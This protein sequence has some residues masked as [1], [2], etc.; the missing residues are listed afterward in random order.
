MK[1]DQLVASYIR[2]RDKKSALKKDLEGKTEKIDLL[3]KDME[4]AI[5]KTFND[6]GQESAR[7]EFGTAYK[8]V[9]TS[10]SVASREDFLGWVLTDPDDR[11]SFLDVRAN[12]TAVEQFRAANDDL[13]PGLN[14]REEVV[15]GVRR[16]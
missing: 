14:W 10:A 1:L 4:A 5:L 11:N 8:S 12:K 15:V 13:P 3:L 9:R 16:S 6:T 7:T 2:L